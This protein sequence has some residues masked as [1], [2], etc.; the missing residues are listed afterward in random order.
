VLCSGAALSTDTLTAL[1]ARLGGAAVFQ[2]YGMTEAN[3]S[4]LKAHLSVQ[5]SGSVGRLY[6]NVEARLV[7]DDLNDVEP[8]KEGEMIV[9]GPTVFVR[10]RKNEKETASTFHNGWMRTGDILRLDDDGFFWLTDRK[11][12]LIKYK[13]NQVA[14]AELESLLLQHPDV[15]EACACA[16]WDEAQGTEL[17]MAYVTFQEHVKPDSAASRDA[18]L[19]NIREFV[20]EKLTPYKRLRGGVEVLDELP[21]TATGKVLRRELPE[22]RK[23]D[24]EK[25]MKG[26]RL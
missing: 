17:P 23:R 4:T 24:K 1:Q 14:P 2:G 10:Y 8:G 13:G 6:A 19:R 26:S 11:K 20:D 9:R 7:D 25:A 22:R 15:R 18:V 3:I 12:E 16:K 21:K 5:K